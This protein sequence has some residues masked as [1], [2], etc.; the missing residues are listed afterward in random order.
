MASSGTYTI[1]LVD[2]GGKVTATS[3]PVA[4]PPSLTCGETAAAITPQPISASNTRAYYADANGVVRFLTP[5]GDS[6]R[7]TTVPTGPSTRS[8]FSVSPDD[9]RIAVVVEQFSSGGASTRLYSEDLNG[10]GNHVEMFTETGSSGLWPIGWH[11][12]MLVVGKVPTCTQGGG[13]GCC[14]PSEFHVVDAT[15]AARSSTVGSSTCPVLGPPT[16]AGA[17]CSTSAQINVLN[18]AGSTL[19]AFPISGFP[20]GYLSPNGKLVAEVTGS[21]T[22]VLGMDRVFTGLQACG[23]ID[24]THLLAGGDQQRQAKVGDINSGTLVAVSAQGTCVGRIPGGL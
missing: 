13:P 7:A 9:T 19:N 15:T 4:V 5:S 24:D 22:N 11:G 14:G 10:A 21:D 3:S 20:S 12:S 17:I 1:S 23:W 18:W 8:S 2:P 6:G 16:P